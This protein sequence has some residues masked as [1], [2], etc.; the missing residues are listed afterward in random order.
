MNIF[1][2]TEF[3]GLHKNT[4]LVS[5]G[6]VSEDNKS[7]YAE[8][9]DYDKGQVD[10]W[11]ET[12]VIRKT[13]LYANPQ[14]EP[15]GE[16]EEGKWADVHVFGP[17]DFVKRCLEEWLGQFHKSYRIEMWGDCLAYDWVLFCDLWGSALRLPK[18]IYY[19]P[20]DLCTL[21][22][23]NEVD[24]NISRERFCG[25]GALFDDLKHTAIWDARV[26]KACYTRITDPYTFDR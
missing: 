9:T 24:A 3:T 1:F 12:N 10:E 13:W 17:K 20:F 19:I 11:L 22:L 2:D 18:K 21:M 7:F 8:F 14:A 16:V 26:I 25:E 4:T 5:I 23:I 6:L 15:S